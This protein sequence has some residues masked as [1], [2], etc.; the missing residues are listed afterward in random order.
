MASSAFVRNHWA[1]S[2]GYLCALVYSLCAPVTC[3]WTMSVC[4]I[5]S[6]VE[7]GPPCTFALGCEQSKTLWAGWTQWAVN[8]G[9]HCHNDYCIV[10]VQYI[11]TYI[12]VCNYIYTHV[13]IYVCMHNESSNATITFVFNHA[14]SNGHVGFPCRFARFL[15]TCGDAPLWPCG[16]RLWI[17]SRQW[18]CGLRLSI[19]KVLVDLWRCAFMAMWASFVDLQ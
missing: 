1:M 14:D 16:L 2:L 8:N 12:Y 18:P 10:Y 17:C 6:A 5:L 19:C 9:R 13:Y 4:S 11:S 3:E 7:L 15:L